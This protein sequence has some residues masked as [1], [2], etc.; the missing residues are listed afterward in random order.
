MHVQFHILNST[1][2]NEAQ[3]EMHK[4]FHLKHTCKGDTDA[5]FFWML[6]LLFLNENIHDWP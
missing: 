5:T 3:S 1:D 4:Q 6:K 2:F